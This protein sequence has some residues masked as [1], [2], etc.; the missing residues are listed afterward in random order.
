MPKLEPKL[1]ISHN[2][3]TDVIFIELSKTNINVI[4]MMK[5]ALLR[6]KMTLMPMRGTGDTGHLISFALA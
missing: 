4:S 6:Q 5:G 1:D 3:K 2:H